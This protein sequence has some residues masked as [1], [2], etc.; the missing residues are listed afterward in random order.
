MAR[1]NY[2]LHF[3][4][5]Q[6]TNNHRAKALHIDSLL[7]YVLLFALFNLGIRAAHKVAPDVLGYATDINVQQ[8]LAGTNAKRQEAG[9]SP[10][11]LN[12]TL[13]VAAANK[14]ADM[15][16]KNYWA[17]NSPSGASPWDFITG[18]GYHYTVAGENLAK[19]FSNSQG[20]VDAW[21][22]SPSHRANVLKSGYQDVGF[23]VVNG[24][25]AGEDTT[26]V[27]QM[28]GATPGEVSAAAPAPAQP[29]RLPARQVVVPAEAAVVNV[30]APATEPVL[31]ME[32]APQAAV[33]GFQS[34]NTQPLFN[35]PT[36]SHDLVFAFV[37]ILMGVLLV[38]AWV[39]SRRHVVR[40]AGHNIAH[41]L[42]LSALFILI[43]GVSRG[44]LL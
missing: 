17:H 36:V 44:R 24:S 21:M 9:L 33:S 12:S 29:A 35:I 8:L 38:D 42:F 32:P 25:L 41:M 20:V 23:A 34:V 3:F 11:T 18:A 30:P 6:H 4:I 15:F 16:A 27:V 7:V 14:A 1:I 10:L 31:A 2:L 37:G 43:S 28:F 22:A 5:P 39:A 19:N 26:L 13:S 40:I